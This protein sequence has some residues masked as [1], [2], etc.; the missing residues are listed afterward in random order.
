MPLTTEQRE[1]LKS[2]YLRLADE[3]L[4]PGN[5]FYEPIYGHDGC[6]DPVALMQQHIEWS[7]TES[8][9]MFSGFRGS[10]KTTELFRLKKN[11]ED[12]GYFVLYG[13]ALKYLNPAQEIDITDL[14]IGL[15][16]TFSDAL[17][18][19]GVAGIAQD[20]YW[21][22]LKNY[23]TTTKVELG[24]VGLKAGADLKLNLETSPTFRQM[25]QQKL[26][27][28]I[29]EIK[30]DVDLFFEDGVKAIRA[31]QGAGLAGIV[32]LFDQMEQIRGTLSNEQ[33]VIHSVERLFSLHLKRLEIPYLHMVYTV[34]PWLKFV[35]PNTVQIQMLPSIRQWN[36]DVAR[37]EY[38]PGRTALRSLVHRRFRDGDFEKFFGGKGPQHDRADKLIDVCGGHFRDLLIL[39]RE[40]V[41]RTP[42]LPVTEDAIQNAIN[43]VRGNYLPIAIDDAKWLNEIEKV[44]GTVLPNT[45]PA[46]VNRL[47]RFLDTHFVLYFTNGKE[48][49]DIHPL[50]RDEVAEIVKRDAARKPA[51]KA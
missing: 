27:N 16:G 1:L 36:N 12:K 24:E 46:S 4:K 10:G 31:K 42:Q 20:S 25:L 39:L 49:Y 6:E 30:R 50:I 8:V 51:A 37:S 7:N 33:S 11:L 44:R 43:A 2:L 3:A 23:L 19:A 9:Q 17:E 26:A 22:R 14:L 13:D 48:W 15:A 5:E 35:L 38:K 18:K 32:F 40:A 21:D 47:T 34:P 41:R 45:D 29:G 28:R